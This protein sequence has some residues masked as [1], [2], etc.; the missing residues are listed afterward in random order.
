MKHK[1]E[2]T[3]D[4]SSYLRRLDKSTQSRIRQ[5]LHELGEDPF[6]VSKTLVGTHIRSSRVGDF[7]ILF[8]VH[9]G[10]PGFRSAWSE[11]TD[12]ETMPHGNT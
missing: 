7:R 9:E 6:A 2:L 4:A 8:E 5:R 11:L 3:R 10:F 1:V 12:H